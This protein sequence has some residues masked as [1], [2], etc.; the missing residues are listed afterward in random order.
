MTARQ[1]IG[2]LVQKGFL[3][4]DRVK[5][6]IVVRNQVAAANVAVIFGDSV[7]A[8][9]AHY[10]R[11][12]LNRLQEGA[13]ARRWNLRYYDELNRE[14]FSEECARKKA[15]L[16]LKDH[17]GDPF[18]GL[19]VFSPGEESIIPHE[20]AGVLPVAIA[21]SGC[22]DTDIYQDY[23]HFGSE[24]IRVLHESGCQ[25]LFF[26]CSHW[27]TQKPPESIFAVISEAQNRNL[28]TPGIHCQKL[29]CQGYAMEKEI[30]ESFQGL[31]RKW[32]ERK[33]PFPDG[34]IFNDDITLRSVIPAILQSGV[35]IPA[36]TRIFSLGS[37]DHRFHYGVP[38]IRYELSQAQ[39]ATHLL[40]ALGQ[41]LQQKDAPP[42]LCLRGAL[43]LEETQ[44]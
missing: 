17:L 44:S 19:I 23:E 14:A 15:E 36:D 27:I 8:E 28:T 10:Y 35:R 38:V 25:R 26:F 11:G 18:N 40:N 6:T 37:E 3:K 12:I 29:H 20:M 32:E 22:P 39:V 16:L 7:T 21:E 31:M 4:R 5:G 24:A 41:R 42:T 1:G 2:L 30:F 13:M 43:V 34:L 9:S 33:E